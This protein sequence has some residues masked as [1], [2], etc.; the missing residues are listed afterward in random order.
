MAY[1]SRPPASR[2]ND[3]D[4]TARCKVVIWGG[5]VGSESEY[6]R[7]VLAAAEDRTQDIAALRA[8]QMP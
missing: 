6:A 4:G 5:V 1:G 8:D 2:G 7:P 3:D